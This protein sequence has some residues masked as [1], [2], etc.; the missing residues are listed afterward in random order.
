MRGSF[1]QGLSTGYCVDKYKECSL[2]ICKDFY[3]WREYFIEEH[4]PENTKNF[5]SF[6]LKSF[7]LGP[8]NICSL[9]KMFCPFDSPVRRAPAQLSSAQHHKALVLPCGPLHGYWPVCEHVFSANTHRLMLFRSP[10]LMCQGLRDDL[11]PRPVLLGYQ[12]D[13]RQPATCSKSVFPTLSLLSC[14]VVLR[15]EEY[16]GS[17]FPPFSPPSPTSRMP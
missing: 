16:S 15:R 2:H 11:A 8:I 9:P 12:H 7:V 6:E 1:S 14:T 5:Q 10:G 17:S 3:I 4:F 13:D